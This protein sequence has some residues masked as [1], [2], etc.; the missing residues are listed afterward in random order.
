MK[1][2]IEKLGIRYFIVAIIGVFVQVAAYAFNIF[3][4]TN[5]KFTILAFL[6]GTIIYNTGIAC[7][8]M[9]IMRLIQK[10]ED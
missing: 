9:I 8:L 6:A 5:L 7:L 3:E 10:K 2:D 1:I 4:V